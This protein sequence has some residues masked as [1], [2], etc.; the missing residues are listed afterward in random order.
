M[1]Y[2]DTPS[3]ISTYITPDGRYVFGTPAQA[4]E[5]NALPATYEEG[6]LAGNIWDWLEQPRVV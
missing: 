1:N 4:E 5:A 2:Y 6:E 3:N